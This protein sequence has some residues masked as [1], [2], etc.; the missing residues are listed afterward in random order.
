ME[1]CCCASSCLAKVQE[2]A[3]QQPP[4]EFNGAERKPPINAF[5]PARRPS[6]VVNYDSAWIGNIIG[7]SIH[8]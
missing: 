3:K 4:M 1:R 8:K 7:I 2:A 5:K 6:N